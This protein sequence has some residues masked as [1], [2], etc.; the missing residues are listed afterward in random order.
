MLTAQAVLVVVIIIIGM[1]IIIP[2]ILI[3][4]GKQ[5]LRAKEGQPEQRKE[6]GGWMD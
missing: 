2:N 5:C 1:I 4:V 6:N 3:S